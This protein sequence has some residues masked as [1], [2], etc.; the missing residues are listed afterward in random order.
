LATSPG[1]PAKPLVSAT[2]YLV[3]FSALL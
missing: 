3:P 1:K 2:C